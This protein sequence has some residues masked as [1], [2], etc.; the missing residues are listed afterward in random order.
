M[1]T[2]TNSGLKRERKRMLRALRQRVQVVSGG[3][4]LIDQDQQRY[5]VGQR[6]NQSGCGRMQEMRVSSGPRGDRAVHLANLP[7]LGFPKKRGAPEA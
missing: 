4:P 1:D 5:S 3:E 2:C 7:H 6:M